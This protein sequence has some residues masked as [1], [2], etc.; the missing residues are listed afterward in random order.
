MRNKKAWSILGKR[1]ACGA[2]QAIYEHVNLSNDTADDK[3]KH[4]ILCASSSTEIIMASVTNASS[5]SD[6]EID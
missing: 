6:D 5:I 3:G 4:V 2:V 1:E